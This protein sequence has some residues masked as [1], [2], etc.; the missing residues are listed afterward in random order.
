MF[1][2][3]AGGSAEMVTCAVPVAMVPPVALVKVSEKV[4]AGSLLALLRMGTVTV[5]TVVPGVKVSV[6]DC[7]VMSLE[8]APVRTVA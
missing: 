5:S 4:S 1:A 6:P 3:R 2:D 7:G 8:S